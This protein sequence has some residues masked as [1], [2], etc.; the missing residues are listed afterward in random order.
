M[1]QEGKRGGV[2]KYD[3]L[4]QKGEGSQK[5]WKKKSVTSVMCSPKLTNK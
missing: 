5:Y 2:M 3:T 4:G 1:C